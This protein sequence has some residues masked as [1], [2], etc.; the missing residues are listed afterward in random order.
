MNP[1]SVT[2]SFEIPLRYL[3]VSEKSALIRPSVGGGDSASEEGDY[4]T[5]LVEIH[6]ARDRPTSLDQEGFMLCHQ[7]TEVADFYSN[8]EIKSIYEGEIKTLLMGITGAHRIEIFDHT[9]RASSIETQ[10]TQGIREPAS[11]IHN[12]YDDESGPRRLRD[13]FPDEADK[14]TENRFAIINT[15]RSIKQ[16]VRNFPLALCDAS[17]VSKDDLVSVPRISKDRVGAVQMATFSPS[18][19][20]CYFPLMRMDEALL[21]KVYDSVDDGRARFTLHT[22]FDDPTVNNTMETNRESIETRCFVFFD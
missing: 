1:S 21:F 12:D 7:E 8:D 9:R 15:W 13:F 10:R 16:P 18:H 4:V 17:S 3:A 14:L 11:T 5:K 2:D 6:D 19:R 20:W 22:S